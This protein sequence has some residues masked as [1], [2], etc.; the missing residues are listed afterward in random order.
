MVIYG[1]QAGPLP[2]QPL[3][4]GDQQALSSTQVWP[5]VTGTEPLGVLGPDVGYRG[6]VMEL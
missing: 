3:V 1:G 2:S 5:C 4:P 6:D